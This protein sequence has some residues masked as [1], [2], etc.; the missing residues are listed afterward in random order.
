MLG[1]S[2]EWLEKEEEIEHSLQNK[3]LNKKM[4]FPKFSTS[5]L[6]FQNMVAESKMLKK[7]CL[8]TQACWSALNT[9]V[10][11]L[12]DYRLSSTE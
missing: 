10:A 5:G 8:L 6:F 9:S 12:S 2:S 11:R 7:S 1:L 3:H 4:C